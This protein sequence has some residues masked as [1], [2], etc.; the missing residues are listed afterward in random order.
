MD[1]NYKHQSNLIRYQLLRARVNKYTLLGLILSLISIL[2]ASLIVSWQLT[3]H[4]TLEGIILAHKTNPAL[5]FLDITPFMFTYWGQRFFY[6]LVW[7]AD[8]IIETSTNK[9]EQF[10]KEL[11]N[12]LKMSSMFD[13]ITGLPN[14]DYL[15]QYCEKA[16]AACDEDDSI[17][18]LVV[19]VSNLQFIQFHKS[20]S[21]VANSLRIFSDHLTKAVQQPT[22]AALSSEL[23]F[24]ARLYSNDFAIVI[25]RYNNF[26]PHEEVLKKLSTLFSLNEKDDEQII[27]Y[28]PIIGATIYPNISKEPTSL[29]SHGLIAI[30]QAINRHEQYALYDPQSTEAYQAQPLILNEVKNAIENRDIQIYFQ[31][32]YDFNTLEIIGAEAL[33]RITNTEFGI[34]DAS[35]FIN[36][37]EGTSLIQQYSY[38]VLDV[39]IQQIA[40]C[41]QAGHRIFITVNLSID[42]IQDTRIVNYI[43]T[44]IKQYNIDPHYLHLDFSEK[45]IV[46][47]FARTLKTLTPLATMGV[48]IAVDDFCSGYSSFVYLNNLPINELKIDK[49]FVMNMESDTAKMRMVKA[50]VAL[51]D[52]F[53][54]RVSAEGVE[55][56]NIVE[57]LTSMGCTRGKGYFFSEAVSKEDFERM[58]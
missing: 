2:I 23:P 21:D 15:L 40:T 1:E 9:F 46:A 5:W 29:I 28:N 12:K 58:L 51:A 27:K 8:S 50:I 31:P 42:D 43:A 10:T 56:K 44:L 26:A 34:L 32:T 47:D 13:K 45:A 20:G 57:K 38:Y 6:S 52:I 37:L 19:A 11:E 22:V 7:E 30:S 18:F 49:Y 25:P 41:H 36:M 53:S 55:S 39:A 33:V 3:G 24:I 17:L 48:G 4:I 35:Q 16:A 14:Q 54:I